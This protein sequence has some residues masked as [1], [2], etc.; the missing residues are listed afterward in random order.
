M[1]RNVEIKARV[2][3]LV[4]L[5]TAV[6]RIADDG[7]ET[8]CQT[9]TFFDSERGRL[10]LRE[11]SNG[12][13]E[14]IHY[15]RA[16]MAEPAESQYVRARVP[17]PGEL[18]LALSRALAVRATVRKKRTLFLVGQTRIHLDEVEELGSFVELEVVLA[19][20]QSTL[21]GAEEASKLMRKLG[22][23]KDD[24]VRGAYVDLLLQAGERATSG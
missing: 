20:G 15:E 1:Q 9:D 11:L 7:P 10:K 18:K 5:R 13:A 6:E 8:L 21:E 14:L 3:D 22:I 4:A 24:L 23:K 17:E 12:R 16:D 19:P 2:H